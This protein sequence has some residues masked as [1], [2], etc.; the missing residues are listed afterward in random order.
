MS[1]P[2]TL[3]VKLSVLAITPH[4][5]DGLASEYYGSVLDA[6]GHGDGETTVIEFIGPDAADNLKGLTLALDSYRRPDGS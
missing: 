6:A 4:V 3:S 5:L 2:L 1:Q